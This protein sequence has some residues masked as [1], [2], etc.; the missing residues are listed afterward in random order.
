M[1]YDGIDSPERRELNELRLARQ[2]TLCEEILNSISCT[3]EHLDK[4]E[5]KIEQLLELQKRRGKYFAS[6]FG[7]VEV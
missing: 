1:E 2:K 6:H 7:K 3:G 5:E 4:T